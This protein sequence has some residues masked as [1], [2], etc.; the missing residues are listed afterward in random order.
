LTSENKKKAQEIVARL[1]NNPEVF[2]KMINYYDLDL[3]VKEK[4]AAYSKRSSSSVAQTDS[5]RKI[6]KLQENKLESIANDFYSN[7]LIR[8][9]FD[10]LFNVYSTNPEFKK[11]FDVD[12]IYT[13]L[14]KNPFIIF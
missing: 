6:L 13:K 9:S 4:M 5:L 3:K 7:T 1:Y 11:R 14:K 12:V 10:S 8:K 2:N